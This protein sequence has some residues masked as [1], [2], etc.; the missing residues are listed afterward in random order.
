MESDKDNLYARWLAG[1]TSPEEQ[2]QL[3]SSGELEELQSII[4]ATDNLALPKYDATKGYAQFRKQHPA[5]ET[6]TIRPLRKRKVWPWLAAAASVALLIGT[7]W[8]FYSGPD[9]IETGNQFTLAHTFPDQT[10]VVLN[11]GSRLSYQE[12]DW[13]EQR[14]VK[15]EGEAIFNVKKG[16]PFIV[17]T[18]TGT[19]EVLGTSFNVRAWSDNLNV[20][21]YEGR[22]QVQYGN[23][24]VI[25][26]KGEAVNGLLGNLNEK[27]TIGHEKPLW[28]TGSSR[29][30]QEPVYQVFAEL[31]RQYDVQISSPKIDRPFNG[32][33]QHGDL[34]TALKAI[35]LPMNL[36]FTIGPE[37]KK[38]VISQ[39]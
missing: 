8:T 33:F 30:Y 27:Q 11:D 21:C 16:K 20:E 14:L 3:Q 35:C 26:N 38:V 19:V 1:E 25:L 5:K 24:T 22:V 39:K 31:E 36:E 12:S 28:S 4:K 9:A 23:R 7:F 17:Q 34:E 29:F 37:G 6:V 10:E 13:K 2:K 15:L 18:N 32:T